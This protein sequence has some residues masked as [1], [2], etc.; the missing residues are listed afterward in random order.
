MEKVKSDELQEGIVFN[1][2]RR[3]QKDRLW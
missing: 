2:M 1:S 3:K